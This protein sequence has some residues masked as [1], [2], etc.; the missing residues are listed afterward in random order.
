[1]LVHNMVCVVHIMVCEAPKFKLHLVVAEKSD[2]LGAHSSIPLKVLLVY[3]IRSFYHYPIQD[4]RTYEMNEAYTTMCDNRVLK[5]KHKHLEMKGLTHLGF[6]LKN[7]EV[8][9]IQFFLS[10]VHDMQIWLEKLGKITKKMVHKVIGLPMLDRPKAKKNIPR[11]ELI[12]NT[13]AEWDGRGLK[14]N[15]VTNLSN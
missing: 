6:M 3:D 15:D 1:M 5:P 13:D 7:F 9:W 8:K 11:D 4:L 2:P 10:W 12:E 14:L